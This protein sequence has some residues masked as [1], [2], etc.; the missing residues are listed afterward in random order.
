M[1]SQPQDWYRAATSLRAAGRS[2]RGGLVS[3][4]LRRRPGN[5]DGL[6]LGVGRAAAVAYC[7]RDRVDGV[8]T[9]VQADLISVGVGV[10]VGVRAGVSHCVAA[11]DRFTGDGD[12]GEAVLHEI[13][14]SIDTELRTCQVGFDAWLGRFTFR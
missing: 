12:P 11:V 6:G 9:R 8:L 2:I 1:R 14:C 4:W 13:R 3:G 10:G 7:Y 5:D